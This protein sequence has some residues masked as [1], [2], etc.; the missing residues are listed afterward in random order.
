MKR[1]SYSLYSLQGILEPQLIIKMIYENYGLYEFHK[2]NKTAARFV[3]FCI[4]IVIIC[5]I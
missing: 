4:P 5:Y 2:Q 3:V 1:K